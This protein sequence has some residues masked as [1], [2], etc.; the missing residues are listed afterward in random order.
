VTKTEIE[1][2][3]YLNKLTFQIIYFRRLAWKKKGRF[4]AFWIKFPNVHA[5]TWM[6]PLNSLKKNSALNSG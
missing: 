4:W 6:C 1:V 2:D 3:Q 5:C